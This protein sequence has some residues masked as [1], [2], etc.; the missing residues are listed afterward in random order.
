[1][2][3]HPRGKNDGM[4]SSDAPVRDLTRGQRLGLR[5]A[6]VDGDGAEAEAAVLDAA[7]AD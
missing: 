4:R 1:M 6:G 3:A 7:E 5:D 2:A